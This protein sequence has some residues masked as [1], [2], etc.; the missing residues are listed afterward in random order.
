MWHKLKPLLIILS[1]VLNLSFIAAWAGGSLL[2]QKK[3]ATCHIQKNSTKIWCP[4]HRR[5]AVSKSQWQE[6][7]PM[8]RTFHDSTNMQ[9]QSMRVLRTE[10]LG[11][12]AAP[13][14]DRDAI[15][16]KQQEVSSGQQKMQQMVI[17]HLLNE[18]NVLSPEQWQ[19]MMGFMREGTGNG[20]QGPLRGLG[21]MGCGRA[22]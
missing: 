17:G 19:M 12:L 9:C 20:G 22:P 13:I 15:A 6:I 8:I 11:L 1:V 21:G 7:E 16:K 10:L 2:N 3:S 18:K 5:L 14:P 4:L